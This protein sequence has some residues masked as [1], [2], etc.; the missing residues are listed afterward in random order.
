MNT[1]LASTDAANAPDTTTSM[2]LLTEQPVASNDASAAHGPVNAPRT[3]RGS[4]A[5]MLGAIR[6]LG[7]YVA[8]E[9]ILP[10]GTIIAL[11]LWAYRNRRSVRDGASAASTAVA[12]AVGRASTWR[13]APC[14]HR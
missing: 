6:S 14:T 2:T 4:I 10:G 3:L 7:P 5:R 8:I 1:A 11:A 13:L 9:L 12:A